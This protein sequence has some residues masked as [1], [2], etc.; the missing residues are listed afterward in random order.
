M[1]GGTG[2]DTAERVL[3][4]HIVRVNVNGTFAERVH[5]FNVQ[6]QRIR[7]RLLLARGSHGFFSRL[8]VM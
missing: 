2:V 4:G 8:C 6:L 3:I 7:H 1:V 5:G